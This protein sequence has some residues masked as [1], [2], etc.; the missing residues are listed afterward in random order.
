LYKGHAL[1]R[2]NPMMRSGTA[3]AFAFAFAF[4]HDGVALGVRQQAFH[5]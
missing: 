2:S 1:D 4:A 3:F 5:Y